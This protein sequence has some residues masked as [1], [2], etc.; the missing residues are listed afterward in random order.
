[1][2]RDI[3]NRFFVNL[4]GTYEEDKFSGFDSRSFVGVGA[5][6]KV[7]MMGPATWTIE[8]GPG[9]RRDVF[10]ATGKSKGTFGA[11]LGSVYAYKFN[12]AV[13]FT[14]DTEVVYSDVSTQIVNIAAVTAKMTD[15]L[16]AR[17][18]YEV[19][20]ESDPPFGRKSTDTISRISL[21]YG[22]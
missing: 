22:F 11:R 21:V 8:G 20:N 2:D 15:K 16:A 1:M 17:F 12:D 7:L 18:S 14:N 3:T 6:Y 5:G 4:R 13:N 10:Q 9:Y 19:R